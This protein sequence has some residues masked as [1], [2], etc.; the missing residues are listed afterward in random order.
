MKREEHKMA[1]FT[2]EQI[3]QLIKDNNLKEAKDIQ[4]MLKNMFAE[5]LQEMLEAELDEELGYTKYDYKSKQT[6]NSRN[7]HSKKKVTSDQGPMDIKIP[8]DREGEFSPQVVKKHENDVSGIEDQILSMYAKGMSVRDIQD[9][10]QNIYGIE[11]SPTL[12]SRITDRIMPLVTEWQNRPLEPV[13]AIVFMDAVHFKVRTDGRIINKAAYVAIGINLD[14]KKDVLG[15][16]IGENESAKYWLNIINELKNRGVKDILIASIDG[17]SGFSEAIRAA[18][19]ETEIQRCIIHQIRSSTKY[20]S[21][22]D[23]KSF[24]S[25]LKLIYRSVN[26]DEALQQLEFLEEKWG[27]KYAIA[28]N[29]WKK[30][31]VELATFFKYPQEVRTLIYTNNAI[32]GYNRQLRKVT[33]AKSSFP[34]DEALLKMLYLATMDIL[35][36]WTTRIKNWSIVLAQLSVYFGNRLEGHI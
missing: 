16:W 20:I 28:I 23:L 10:L 18:F 32:E 31:W 12:I 27:S 34:T 7:G 13:Y 21:Y 5:T 22:K 14:G 3:R 19:P 17:L 8:R 35:K 15:I 6:A 9:H 4:G 11:A 36:K 33:K 24:T 30:N 29:S 25:D 1:I 26:E 2:K